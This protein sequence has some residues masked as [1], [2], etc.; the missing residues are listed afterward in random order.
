MLPTRDHR[1]PGAA[2]LLERDEVGLGDHPIVGEGVARGEVLGDGGDPQALA[3]P[4]HHLL[5]PGPRQPVA[6]H[7]DLVPRAGGA[8][9]LAEFRDETVDFRRIEPCG[10]LGRLHGVEAFPP[11]KVQ[12]DLA[13]LQVEGSLDRALEAH[14]LVLALEVLVHPPGVLHD[15]LP[16][17][18]LED[19][20]SEGVIIIFKI[21]EDPNLV[22]RLESR[23]IALQRLEAQGVLAGLDKP[24]PGLSARTVDVARRPLVGKD[25]E[26]ELL[27]DASDGCAHV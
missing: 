23:E 25:L 11:G 8:N 20:G 21:K 15:D 13:A 26:H 7:G 6:Q 2:L 5:L 12:L 22:A 27:L 16:G 24:A 18:H 4:H 17:L 19:L 1:G 9:L 14:A 3:Q 10:R